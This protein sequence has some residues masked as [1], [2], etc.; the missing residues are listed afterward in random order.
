MRVGVVGYLRPRGLAYDLVAIRAAL[1][2][3]DDIELSVFPVKD[4]HRVDRIVRRR[5]RL[6]PARPDRGWGWPE[7]ERRTDLLEWVR[8]LD[9]LLTLE[10]FLPTV[11][12]AAADAGVRNV[13]VPNLEWISDRERFLDRL[14]SV[15]R[16]V[17]KTDHTAAAFA[18]WGLANVAP[19]PWSIDLAPEPPRPTGAPIVFLH[20]C[21]VGSSLEAKN[22]EAVLAAFAA[23]L[24]DDPRARLVVHAQVPFRRRKV[25]LDVRPYRRLGNVTI[26]EGERSREEVLALIRGADAAVLPSRAEGF[27]LSHLECLT[28]GVPVLTTDAPPMNELVR[29]GRNG[30]LAP[31]R[32]SGRHRHVPVAEVDRAALAGM[33]VRVVEEP[34]LADRLKR[35]THEG[36]S[37]RRAAFVDGLRR[38]LREA[39][40]GSR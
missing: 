4:L 14:R 32:E 24:G 30:L 23:A 1:A 38:V 13:H 8:T 27:G 20:F 26:S 21:G 7:A 3:A 9:V 2:G 29:D 19:V 36:L 28:L 25:R 10:V 17:A 11:A 6:R 15:D 33:M 39:A 40:C 35:G 5:S 37:E 18:A 12:R 22:P 34:G 31:T 16:L